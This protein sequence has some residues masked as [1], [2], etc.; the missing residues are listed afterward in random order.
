MQVFRGKVHWWVTVLFA[1]D[2][3]RRPSVHA[4]LLRITKRAA[5]GGRHLDRL[6]DDHRDDNRYLAVLQIDR[7]STGAAFRVGV[8]CDGAATEH[9]L[10]EL[11]KVAYRTERRQI[12][13]HRSLE[14]IPNVGPAIARNLRLIVVS[15]PEELW[16]RDP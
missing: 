11:A 6:G 5:G 14:N 13:H 9:H 7:L 3:R 1:I 8:D 15:S 10:D 4:A 16:G 12:R 2:L